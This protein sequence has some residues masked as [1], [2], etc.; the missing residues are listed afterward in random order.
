MICSIFRVY[1]CVEKALPAQC[2]ADSKQVARDAYYRF[3]GY[4]L[5][6]CT[7]MVL[8]FRVEFALQ[9]ET[10]NGSENEVAALRNKYQPFVSFFVT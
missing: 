3:V 5:E 8:L 1:E 10:L 6:S 9:N 7:Q 2:K 4:T